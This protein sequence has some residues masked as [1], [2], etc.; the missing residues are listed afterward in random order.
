MAEV[1]KTHEV[2]VEGVGK[3]VCWRTTARHSFD[4][5]KRSR[6]ILGGITEDKNLAVAAVAIATL[7]ALVFDGPPGWDIEHVDPFD[8]ADMINVLLVCRSLRDAEETFRK[9]RKIASAAAG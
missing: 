3:F 5:A 1:E 7:E 8:D 9:A 2:D 6:E 4:I